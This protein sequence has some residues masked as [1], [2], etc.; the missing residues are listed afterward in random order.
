MKDVDNN[1]LRDTMLA[2]M[3]GNT[4]ANR[5]PVL[6]SLI[7]TRGYL[8]LCEKIIEKAPSYPVVLLFPIFQREHSPVTLFG[9]A[10]V[11]ETAVGLCRAIRPQEITQ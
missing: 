4:E 1:V 3:L 8:N 9:E 7:G 6:C 10:F 2:M 5:L 11:V